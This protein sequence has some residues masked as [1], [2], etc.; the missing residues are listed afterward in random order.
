V[1]IP[2]KNNEKP[3]AEGN[4][5][6]EPKRCLINLTERLVKEKAAE[7]MKK[8]NVCGCETCGLDVLAL[9]LNSLQNKYVTTDAGRQHLLLNIYQKQ[10]ET[11]I[12]AALTKACVRVKVSPRHGE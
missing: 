9:A 2:V 5:V 8:M 10:Y 11:D 12:V 7:V 6:T 3:K 4:T 1:Q